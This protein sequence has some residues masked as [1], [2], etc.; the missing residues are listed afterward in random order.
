V[1]GLINNFYQAKTE[2]I[3]YHGPQE[4]V[5]ITGH[6]HDPGATF[7]MTQHSTHHIGMALFPTPSVLLDFPRI[8]YISHKI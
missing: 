4:F 2:T 8:N 1:F 7:G 3:W 6:V 5:M